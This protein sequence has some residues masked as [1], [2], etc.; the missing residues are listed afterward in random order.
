MPIPFITEQI[1]N[2][3]KNTKKLRKLLKIKRDKHKSELKTE[4]NRPTGLK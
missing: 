2:F 3:P 4:A 1:N